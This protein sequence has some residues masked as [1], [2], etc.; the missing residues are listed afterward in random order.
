MGKRLLSPNK[1]GKI[2]TELP[3][4]VCRPSGAVLGESDMEKIIQKLKAASVRAASITVYRDVASDPAVSRYI[5]LLRALTAGQASF[6]EIVGKE[7]A[8]C[9]LLYASRFRGNFYDYLYHKVLVSDSLF[10]Q[11]AARDR[12]EELPAC[13][14]TAARRDLDALYRLAAISAAEVAAVL[15]VRCPEE[16]AL[17]EALPGYESR[18]YLYR[19]KGSWGGNIADIAGYYR[20]NGVGV[21]SEEI[22]FRFD[23]VRLLPVKSIDPIRLSDLKHYEAQRSKI[24]ENTLSFLHGK[25]CN[26][27]LLYGDR[28]TGKS[29]TVKALLNAYYGDGLRIVQVEKKDLV[30]MPQLMEMLADNPLKFIIF[31]DDLTFSENDDSFGALKAALEGSLTRKADNM[32][33]YATSNR[34]HLIKETFTSRE[35]DEV[36]RADTI[37]DSLSLSDRFGLTITFMVPDKAK[38]LDIVAKIAKDRGLAVDEETLLKGAERFALQKAGRSPRIAQQYID[39]VQGRLEMG[40][41]ML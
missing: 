19:D 9:A 11:E 6:D 14:L 41:P 20:H 3:P 5:D 1:R 39:A 12:W 18:P 26:N 35:G 32:V 22:A 38:F 16:A 34:R 13:V 7:A 8:F 25:P 15:K 30:A 24:V 17:L 36:H 10:A 23:G 4:A 27:I 31:I 40:L 28:G 33:I 2:K 37:D 21:F 29:S